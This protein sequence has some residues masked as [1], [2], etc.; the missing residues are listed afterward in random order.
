MVELTTSYQ[1]G[2]MSQ[3][4]Y[5]RRIRALGGAALGAAGTPAI[6]PVEPTAELPAPPPARPD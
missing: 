1:A 2:E 6:S 5:L 3:D 4:E